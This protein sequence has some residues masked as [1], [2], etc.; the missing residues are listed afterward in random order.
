MQTL[1]GHF[2]SILM[3]V[4]DWTVYISLNVLAYAY[5]HA[6]FQYNAM[7]L[8]PLGCAE[9]L[10]EAMAQQPMCIEHSLDGWYLG[11]SLGHYQTYKSNSKKIKEEH[12]CDT[13][14]FKHKYIIQPMVIPADAIIRAVKELMWTLQGK[15][16]WNGTTGNN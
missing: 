1:K 8:A 3:G 11:M 14:F 12:Y 5:L 10:H 9:Q 2:K 4:N 6:A 7:S 13:V 15:T 16:M